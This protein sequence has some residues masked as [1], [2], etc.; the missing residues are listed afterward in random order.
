MSLHQ[1]VQSILVFGDQLLECRP[2]ALD[3]LELIER[4]ELSN[5]VGHLGVNQPTVMPVARG[6]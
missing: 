4:L 5:E 1:P 2:R 3:D 6:A